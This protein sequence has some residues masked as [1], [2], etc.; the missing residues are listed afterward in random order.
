MGKRK[1]N[2]KRKIRN[3][4]DDAVL[5]PLSTRVFYVGSP[6]HKINPGDFGLT[7]PSSPRPDKTLCDGI[8][9]FKRDKAQGLLCEG[10]KR[11]LISVQERS[12]LPQNIW[13]VSDD[14]TPLEAQLD[15]QE[16]A[17][18]HGY[19]MQEAD[20]LSREI[21]RRWNQNANENTKERNQ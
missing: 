20:P 18:Y 13:A 11:G 14:G 8:R 12:G 17:T 4:A 10:V 7:P 21:L 5:A 2:T 9:V 16:R 1:F 19:P 6:L 15:N 3:G